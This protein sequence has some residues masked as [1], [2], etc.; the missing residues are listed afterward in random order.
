MGTLIFLAFMVLLF[1]YTTFDKWWLWFVLINGLVA[2]SGY[3]I[4]MVGFIGAIIVF[5]VIEGVFRNR[6]WD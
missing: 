1:K 3:D 4:G 2:K 5:K 6:S